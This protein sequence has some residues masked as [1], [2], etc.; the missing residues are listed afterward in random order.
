MV[1][2]LDL[3]FFSFFFF[4]FFFF[5]SPENSPVLFRH[6]MWFSVWA[7]IEELGDISFAGAARSPNA[8]VLAMANLYI[9]VDI[10]ALS[11][12]LSLS[13]LSLSLSLS[14]PLSLSLCLSACVRPCV[15]NKDNVEGSN[16]LKMCVWCFCLYV[17]VFSTLICVG[18]DF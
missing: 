15:F 12:S 5:F 2:T 8:L 14:L 16:S 6:Q 10:A 17:V 11:L 4:F 7:F 18:T 9:F 13:S 3:F 1:H